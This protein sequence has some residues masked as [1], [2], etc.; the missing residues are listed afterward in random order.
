MRYS[1][2]VT[3]LRPSQ[4]ATRD[5]GA[6]RESAQISVSPPSSQTLAPCTAIV[7]FLLLRSSFTFIFRLRLL[8]YS[9]APLTIIFRSPN[10]C[11]SPDC[12]DYLN[13]NMSGRPLVGTHMNTSHDN[14][15][16][17]SPMDQPPTYDRYND[18]YADK[19]LH[20]HD[21]ER[22]AFDSPYDSS[23]PYVPYGGPGYSDSTE[24]RRYEE[25]WSYTDETAP[26]TPVAR[27]NPTEYN[28]LFEQPDAMEL[29][30]LNPSESKPAESWPPPS[31]TR[32]QREKRIDAVLFATGIGRLLELLRVKQDIPV[33]E[34]INRKRSNMLPQKWPIMTYCLII[35]MTC[36]MI[37][38][39]IVNKQKTGS[40]IATKPTF[41]YMIGPSFEVLINIGARFVPYAMTAAE[42]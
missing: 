36:L 21:H 41:N 14:D 22:N 1:G 4:D 26:K 24:G 12:S 34:A 2:K 18:R 8:T 10:D 28:P 29:R 40:V 13:S 11:L 31:P 19:Q 37:W 7:I 38:E 25:P 16:L 35:I 15:H 6:G 32:S 27:P 33:Q 5:Y 3:R 42:N 23:T 20:D 30:P 9:Q 39:L 17:D